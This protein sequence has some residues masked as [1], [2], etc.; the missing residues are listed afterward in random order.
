LF[1]SRLTL[2]IAEKF[3]RHMLERG[4]VHFNGEV[5]VESRFRQSPTESKATSIV[6]NVSHFRAY[7][8]LESTMCLSF[9]MLALTSAGE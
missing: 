4:I 5:H 9:E 6:E 7:R 8:E 1:L 2:I 3:L